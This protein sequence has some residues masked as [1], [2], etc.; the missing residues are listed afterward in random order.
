MTETLSIPGPAGTLQATLTDADAAADAMTILCHPHPQYGGSMDDDVLA[1]LATA[2]AAKASAVL[3]F[4]F[5]GV[6]S[7][8]GAYSG[9][10]GEVDDLRAVLIWARNQYPA[11][12]LILG[13]YSFG[14]SIVAQILPDPG[15]ALERVL[16]VA[17]PLGNLPL[18]IPDGTI[19]VDL[20]VGDQDA[21]ADL[22]ALDQ[23]STAR[24]H[25]LEGADHFFSGCWDELADRIRQS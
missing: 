23:W 25:I 4:N 6:G 18:P 17:P 1:I 3:R 13:G 15:T 5:R 12:R 20:F 24:V 21:F 8:A 22:D 19:P 10:G 7:S 16:L 2:L 11:T 9:Q 14:A